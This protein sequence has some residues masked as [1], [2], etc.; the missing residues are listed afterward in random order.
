MP[1]AHS[2]KCSDLLSGALIGDLPSTK[3]TDSCVRRPSMGS[4][5]GQQQHEDAVEKNTHIFLAD[6]RF[7]KLHV[8]HAGSY[9]TSAEKKPAVLYI[10]LDREAEHFCRCNGAWGG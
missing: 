4:R 7:S 1:V 10:I 3:Y 5:P 9:F 6:V 2:K 8:V